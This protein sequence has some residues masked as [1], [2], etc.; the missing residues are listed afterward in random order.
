MKKHTLFCVSFFL[1]LISC[2]KPKDKIENVIL[3]NDG[4]SYWNYEWPRER[5]EYY[6][7]TFKFMKGN[8]LQKLSFDK[9]EN[10]RSVWNDY[11]YEKSIYRWGISNDSIFTFMNYNSKIKIVKYNRDTIWLHDYERNRDTKLI[12]VT[13]NLN[14]EK[15]VESKAFD[16]KTEKEIK[17]LNM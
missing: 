12:K 8:K 14:I 4:Y 1:I 2:T 9:V 5:A 16:S 17:V 15:S 13:G 7:F 6:G 3:Y 10:K 11:P